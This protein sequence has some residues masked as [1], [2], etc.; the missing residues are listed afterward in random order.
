MEG[1][2]VSYESYLNK[3]CPHYNGEYKCIPI[4]VEDIRRRRK[5]AEN[6][7]SWYVDVDVDDDAIE[8][9]KKSKKNRINQWHYYSTVVPSYNLSDLETV[10]QVV[11]EGYIYQ[12]NEQYNNINTKLAALF[13]MISFI[14][15]IIII[16][17]VNV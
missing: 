15:C 9:S 12:L 7:W 2:S 14:T 16:F 11:D 5:D 4:K 17:I 3:I 10:V 8:E 6:D 13:C 1:H